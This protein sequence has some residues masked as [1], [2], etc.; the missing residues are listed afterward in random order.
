MGKNNKKERKKNENKWRI[1]D[2]YKVRRK[3]SRIISRKAKKKVEN[4]NNKWRR[5]WMNEKWKKIFKRW[6]INEGYDEWMINEKNK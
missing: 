2:N 4:M 6:I 5:W 3:I 1:S